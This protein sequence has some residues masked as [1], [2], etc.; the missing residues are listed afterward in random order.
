MN[1]TYPITKLLLW[2]L[3]LFLLLALI[4][5]GIA[6]LA[7]PAPIFRMLFDRVE[8]Q[9]GISI[10]FDRVYILYDL[11]K[12]PADA[13][14]RGRLTFKG[15]ALKRQNHPVINFDLTAETV[16]FS[17]LPYRYRHT[18]VSGLRGTI[19]K[20]GSRRDAELSG[21][22]SILESDWMDTFRLSRFED[23][24]VECIDR[25]LAEPFH[26]TVRLEFG[27]ISTIGNNTTS[28]L[29]PY[30]MEIHGQI[31][32]APFFIAHNYPKEQVNILQN[33]RIG[34]IPIALFAPY[35]PILDDIFAAGTM[36]I[37][38]N[39]LSD[40]SQK[41]LRLTITLQPDCRIKPADALLSPTIQTALQDLDDSVL[42]DLLVLQ[43]RVARLRRNTE[44]IR[45]DLDRVSGIIEALRVL[46]PRDVRQQYDRFRVQYDRAVADYD[47]WNG[48]VETLVLEL[49]RIKIRVIEDTFERFI[50]SG[51]P[52]VI[53]LQEL[54]GDW[55]FDANEAV[56]RLLEDNYRI[57][58]LELQEHIR[59]VRRAVERLLSGMGNENRS[60]VV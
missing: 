24:E 11:Q 5:A 23:I 26:T 14:R 19:E 25:T 29:A 39:D 60:G 54:D 57:M 53:E 43:E 27:W 37:D 49:D 44:S 7:Q 35:A 17:F 8:T 22:E 41:K 4:A 56:I 33:A 50:E 18:T 3:I 13:L 46:A 32:S 52:I 36:N 51:N 1:I 55:V 16:R 45:A 42:P 48:R 12:E 10:T 20:T 58:V 59:E 30:V 9:T 40:A 38:A 21:A 2:L 47:E 31:D 28:L 6:I 15:L 34:R